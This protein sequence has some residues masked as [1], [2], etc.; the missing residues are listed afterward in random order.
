MTYC[1]ALGTPN[2]GTYCK[3]EEAKNDKVAV[4]ARFWSWPVLG[5]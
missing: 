4:V 5:L 3:V 1:L 2:S